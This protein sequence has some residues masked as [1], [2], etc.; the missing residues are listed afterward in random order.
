MA[1]LALIDTDFAFP[2]DQLKFDEELLTAGTAAIRFW[3]TD[4]ECVVLGNSGRCERDVNMLACQEAS[5]PVLRRSS[6]GGAVLLGPGCLNYTLVLP[7]SWN[8]AWRDVQGSL[9][10]VMNRMRNAIALDDLRVEGHCDLAFDGRKVS[11]NAQRRTNSTILHHGTLLY[12]FDA[13]RAEMFLR[14]PHR[15]PAWRATR[16]HRD[17]MGNLPLSVAEIRQR[18]KDDWC[19]SQD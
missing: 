15:Q 14:P 5:I 10:W 11:G 7:L 12:N 9:R 1:A 19:G 2:A 8:A 13:A 6:G 18:L 3:E 16:S 4:Q 17:F